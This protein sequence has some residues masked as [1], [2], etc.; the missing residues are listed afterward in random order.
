MTLKFYK[1]ACPTPH[2]QKISNLAK[3]IVSIGQLFTF[4]YKVLKRYMIRKIVKQGINWFSNTQIRYFKDLYE[5][6]LNAPEFLFYHKPLNFVGDLC[7][8]FPDVST[9]IYR[10]I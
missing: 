4:D 3:K 9:Y 2:L 1:C 5:P 8:N 7:Y 6:C 10:Y